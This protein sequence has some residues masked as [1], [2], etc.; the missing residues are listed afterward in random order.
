MAEVLLAL[1]LALV[2][3]ALLTAGGALLTH[4]LFANH[5][6]W[7]ERTLLRCVLGIALVPIVQ[8]AGFELLRLPIQPVTVLVVAAAGSWLLLRER[9]RS[10]R[11][12]RA[13]AG[14]P[15]IGE[16][17]VAVC[18]VAVTLSCYVGSVRYP[19]FEAR[20]PWG[21]LLGVKYLVETGQLRQPFAD[22]PILHYIDGYPPLYDIL[23]A[24]PAFLASS[25]N[26]T[27]KATNALVVGL[28]TGVFF[29]LV[30]RLSR[31]HAVAMTATVLLVVLP[32]GLTRQIWG[33]SVAVLLLLAGLLCALRARAVRRWIVPGAICFAGALLAAPTQGIKA[34]ML[35]ILTTGLALLI[36]KRWAARL[37]VMGAGAIAIAMIWFL[38]LLLRVELSPQGLVDSMDHPSLRRSGMRWQE[39]TPTSRQG[40]SAAMLGSG[41]SETNLDD[42]LFVRPHQFMRR[43]FPRK[44]LENVVPQGVGV[45]ASILVVLF[46]LS[47]PVRWLRHRWRVTWREIALV[48]LLFALVGVFGRHLGIGFYV[49]RFWMLVCPFAAIVAAERLVGLARAWNRSAMARL[50]LHTVAGAAVAHLLLCVTWIGEPLLLRFYLLNPTFLLVIAA[51]AIWAIHA[52]RSGRLGLAQ[53]AFTLMMLILGAHVVVATPARLRALTAFVKPSI[54]ASP[55]EYTGYAKMLEK[56]RPGDTVFTLAGDDHCSAIVALDRVCRPWQP[57][58]HRFRQRLHDRDSGITAADTVTWLRAQGYQYLVVDPS[59]QK[60]LAHLWGRSQAEQYFQEL[61]AQPGLRP[62]FTAGAEGGSGNQLVFI[63][64]G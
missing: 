28:V 21:H 48:W 37:V 13:T 60:L 45:A 51:I 58:E 1:V 9:R 39:E 41:H 55:I 26:L 5:S 10:S 17:M 25:L 16:L 23:L 19:M 38:P 29:L 6:T 7:V 11:R 52:A 14:R 59:G 61:L 24:F 50:A 15:D 54:F 27:A 43:W 40:L 30:R 12:Q 18:T 8:I 49:W 64:L 22:W 35:L 53:P 32:G 44:A 46:V 4:G 3:A 57:A 33:H 20:D 47:L 62:L 31:S 63:K 42:F 34:G 2:Y 56:T 36:S